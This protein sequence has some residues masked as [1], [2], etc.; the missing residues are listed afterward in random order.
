MTSSALSRTRA[1]ALAARLDIGIDIP[2]CFACLGIV[3]CELDVGDP[4]GAQRAA[5]EITPFIWHEGLA[6]PALA[7]VRRARDDG[8]PD[9]DLG[10]AD[11]VQR[12][13]RS[14]VARAIV[15]RLAEELSRRVHAEARLMDA[16]RDRLRRSPP[17]LN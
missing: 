13:A 14:S 2:I 5:R 16:T 8:I 12:G 10:L 4:A 9:A 11:L 3:A 17:W 1:E 6:E 15:L 7:A